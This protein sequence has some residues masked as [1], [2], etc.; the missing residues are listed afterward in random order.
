MTMRA[1]S[2][3]WL[4]AV[5]G[6]G[7]LAGCDS[8][9]ETDRESPGTTSGVSA[10]TSGGPGAAEMPGDAGA[11]L[12]PGHR[13]AQGTEF[14]VA[15]PTPEA[16][17]AGRVVLENGGNAVDAAAA[18]AIALWVTD[19]LMSSVGGR[20]QILIRLADGTVVGIDGA[21]QAPLRVDEPAELGHGY[22][23][24]P[25]PGAPAAL[26]EMLKD[27]GTLP[28]AQVM[29][30]AIRL[31]EE[32][33]VVK[34]DVHEYLRTYEDRLSL[35]SGTRTH[36]FKPDGSLYSEG[37]TLRQPA[38]ATTLRAMAEAGTDALYRGPL[39]DAIVA[40]ME[41]HGGLVQH[42]DLDQ[43]RPLVGEVVRGEYRGHEIVARGGN[44]DGASVIQMLQML[45]HFDLGAYDPKDPE[46]VH[47]LAQTL[48][49]GQ[50][51]EHVPDSV[52]VSADHAASRVRE[53]DL[54]GVLPPG[55]QGSPDGDTNH[56]S[57]VDGEGNAVAITQSI[58]PNFGSKVVNPAL[59]FFYAYSYDMNDDPVPFQREKTSQS[60]TM[61]LE[62]GGPFLVLGS[63]G[64]SRIPGSIVRTAVNV[65]DHGLSLWDAVEAPRWFIA[66]GELRIESDEFSAEALDGL[67]GLG[68][69]LQEYEGR[70]GYFAR[71]HAV[72][73]D[74]RAGLLWGASD[75]RDLGAAGG[76]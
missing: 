46:Y 69:V 42:D 55:T 6:F 52:Q 62:D 25:I 17:E 60:P 1:L 73:A 57:V 61:I 30:P 71:V 12:D 63:A 47:I 36:F 18:T 27:Y 49:V 38:L 21:T 65:I 70:D 24:A 19:P 67:R 66:D 23:T 15:A 2:A 75:P 56:L 34:S 20:A 13:L 74:Q 76:R 68:Y 59:G 41:E 40:D 10:E 51:D 72:M 45:E 58:G 43:Y 14:M 32:G 33:F 11:T 9:A 39:A 29:E 64:S 4:L 53:I 44:C 26:E 48:H 28:L 3:Q 22:G 54:A 35:Y 50:G 16:M 5:V 31:A 7:L 8:R 37:D